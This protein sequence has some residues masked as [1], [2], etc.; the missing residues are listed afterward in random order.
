MRYVFMLLWIV[1]LSLGS[2]HAQVSVNIGINLPIYPE[3]VRVPGYPVYYAPRLD[4]NFF[5]YDGMYWVYQRD[6][7]Y[8]SSWYNGPWRLVAPDFVPPFVLRV[9][10][11]Y[12]RNPPGYFRGWRPDASPHWGEHWGRDWAQHRRGWD[13]WNRRSTPAPAPL[14]VYQRQYSGERYPHQIEQQRDIHSQNYRYRP[15]DT[16]VRQQDQAPGMQRAP[17]PSRQGRQDAPQEPSQRPPDRQQAIPP[18][19]QQNAPGAPN[20]RSPQRDGDE[21]RRS[22]SPQAPARPDPAA[23]EQ[24][25]S[26]AQ[27]A[28]PRVQRGPGPGHEQEKG[29]E[30]GEGHGQGRSK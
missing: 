6:N 12:Y 17:A 1:F 18:P 29:R 21:G 15:R 2:A 9:P 22:S 25:A 4:S 23:Q 16:L 26:P 24:K 8:A 14:P 13:K 20:S 30:S 10:V 5:F 7:W 28:A 3:L 19:H 11:R 27:G